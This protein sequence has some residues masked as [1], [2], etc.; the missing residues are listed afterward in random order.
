M[1]TPFQTFHEQIKKNS[2]NSVSGRTFVFT[3]RLE[4]WLNSMVD[5]LEPLT[6]LEIL[7][8]TVVANEASGNEITPP[9]QSDSVLIFCILMQLGV[10]DRLQVF[11]ANGM[12]DKSLPIPDQNLRALA[13]DL[14]HVGEKFASKFQEMQWQ[15]LPATFDLDGVH[16]WS[17]DKIIPICYQNSIAEGRTAKVY[18]VAIPEDF[19]GLNLA[20]AFP[21][22]RR[23]LN[24]DLH[25]NPGWVSQILTNFTP[26]A[27]KLILQYKYY[28]FALKTFDKWN[29][30][31][32]E[33][34]MANFQKIESHEGFVCPLAAFRSYQIQSS[35][36]TKNSDKSTYCFNILFELCEM[37]LSSYFAAKSP[38][39]TPRDIERFWTNISRVVEALSRLHGATVIENGSSTKHIGYV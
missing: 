10:G 4:L 37:D 21:H 24:S 34:E 15:Y 23:Y 2:D 26:R 35:K 31:L 30:K 12:S 1:E 3:K 18:E 32:G 22:C 39:V 11:V 25:I 27:Q 33:R 29:T 38:P 7:F 19:I 28:R 16:E 13:K 36:T 14:G 6:M 5:I 20:H 17:Q 8:D 9:W